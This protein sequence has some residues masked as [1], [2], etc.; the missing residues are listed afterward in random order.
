MKCFFVSL[1]R[2]EVFVLYND[3]GSFLYS[4]LLN[5]R[6]LI[7]KHKLVT[8]VSFILLVYQRAMLTGVKFEKIEFLAL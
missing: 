3:F 8:C 2:K 5:L 1:N 4:I 6:T 7:V